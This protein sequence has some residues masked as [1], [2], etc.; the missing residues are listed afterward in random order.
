MCLSLLRWTFPFKSNLD[1]Y[2]CIFLNGKFPF[3][4]TQRKVSWQNSYFQVWYFWSFSIW[5]N[6][7]IYVYVDTSNI[8][9][10][11]IVHQVLFLLHLWF[12]WFLYCIDWSWVFIESRLRKN[13]NRMVLKNREFL[14][15]RA[16]I[17]TVNHP[18][19]FKH[20]VPII[21]RAVG[22]KYETIKSLA[23]L[24]WS[25]LLIFMCFLKS[26]EKAKGLVGS[27]LWVFETW[28]FPLT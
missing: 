23:G 11:W 5:I 18:P 4:K 12:C 10:C 6:S 25:W 1:T 19:D 9:F 27:L 28:Q 14:Q 26:I 2:E 16:R 13:Y 24:W 21:F 8:L 15:S 20:I 7:K 17:V 3:W 22:R